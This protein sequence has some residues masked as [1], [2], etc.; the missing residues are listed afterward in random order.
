MNTLTI[1]PYLLD[2][3]LVSPLI[4]RV[5]VGLFVLSLASDAYKKFG[6]L[7]IV[8]L[9]VAVLLLL[10]LYTQIASIL[11]VLV[12]KYDLYKNHWSKRKVVEISKNTYFLYGLAG[13]VLLSL[14]F[15]GPGF[16]A[17]DL[18]F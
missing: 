8:Y 11:G 1:F 3:M 16:M 12:L 17:F 2:Y 6:L 13:V 5:F 4:L 18:P 15:T 14:I 10:G 9:G 7:A